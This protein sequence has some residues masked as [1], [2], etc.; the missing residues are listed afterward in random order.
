MSEK[1]D[2]KR[3]NFRKVKPDMNSLIESD[4]HFGF[5]VGYT[6]NGASYGLSH[7]EIDEIKH[8]AKNEKT[9]SDNIDLP[10]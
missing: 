2:R 3:K 9:G 4:E 5:I 1:R 8:D 10:F 6:S 7:E